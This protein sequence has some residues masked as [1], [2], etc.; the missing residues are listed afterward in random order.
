[1][2]GCLFPRRPE[3]RISAISSELGDLVGAP[4]MPL[5]PLMA[6]EASDDL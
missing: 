2:S 1:M 3:V 5:M 4:L 6:A